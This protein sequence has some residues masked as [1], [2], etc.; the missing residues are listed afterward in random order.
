MP[1]IED[2]ADLAGVSIATVSRVLNNSYI[3]SQDKKDK[4]LSA[5]KTLNYQA[6]TKRQSPK[7]FKERL[8]L[9]VGP[10]GSSFPEDI[11]AGLKDEAAEQDYDLV[12]YYSK[13][14]SELLSMKIISNGVCSGI[15]LS[16]MISS[17]ADLNQLGTFVPFIQCGEFIHKPHTYAVSINEVKASFEIV[18]HFLS[19]GRRKIAF[20][21]P[22][23]AGKTHYFIH[24]REKGYRLALAEAGLQF[25]RHLKF[26]GEFSIESGIGV[27]NEIL[28]QNDRPDAVFCATDQLAFGCM[29]AFSEADIKIPD[30]IAIAGFDDADISNLCRP[31]LTTVEQPFYE[32]GRACVQML[33]SLICGQY[34]PDIGRHMIIDHKLKFRAST[35]G[36][37]GKT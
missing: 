31:P 7:A 12:F 16:N 14:L 33:S 34:N 32:I 36:S 6:P 4:V 9:A 29:L 37:D 5:V 8:I 10:G 28:K 15:I 26:E 30:D 35:V 1:T 27:G 23:L 2:V 19:L 11:Q 21:A 24:E 22:V 3:V 25:D 17:C 20:V 18:N 13:D